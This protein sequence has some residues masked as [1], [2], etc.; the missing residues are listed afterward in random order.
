MAQVTLKKAKKTSSPCE[1]DVLTEVDVVSTKGVLCV[2]PVGDVSVWHD[3]V[4][5]P[6]HDVLTATQT[7][8]LGRPTGP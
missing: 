8:T 6:V 1:R 2:C 7:N 5:P 3:W 4:D